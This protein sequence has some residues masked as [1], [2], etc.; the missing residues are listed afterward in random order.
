MT[1]GEADTPIE[2]RIP[3]ITA[4]ILRTDGLH[5]AYFPLLLSP[6]GIDLLLRSASTP[7]KCISNFSEL[8]VLRMVDA[9]VCAV[10]DHI[11]DRGLYL[12]NNHLI[13]ASTAESSF[14]GPH[15][16]DHCQPGI[17]GLL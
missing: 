12:R 7:S 2:N 4:P 11:H 6:T 5:V 13:E 8:L 14:H 10:N 16:V 15:R 3:L 9:L 17:V 1:E